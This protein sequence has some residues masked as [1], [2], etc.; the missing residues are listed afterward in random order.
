MN[1]LI[2]GLLIAFSF[3]EAD[4]DI[5]YSRIQKGSVEGRQRCEGICTR[6]IDEGRKPGDCYNGAVFNICCDGNGGYTDGKS[7][8]CKGK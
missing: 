5:L 8:E 3:R 6:C 2:L 7:C 1:I 4:V